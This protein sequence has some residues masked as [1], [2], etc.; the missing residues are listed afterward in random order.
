[1]FRSDKVRRLSTF[2]QGQ[3]GV[4]VDMVLE[5]ELQGRLMGMG[6]FAGTKFQLL[7]GGRSLR[8]LLLAVGETRISLGKEIAKRILAE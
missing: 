7:Q 4:V 8:P 6:L 3:S 1:M 2:Q 5:P